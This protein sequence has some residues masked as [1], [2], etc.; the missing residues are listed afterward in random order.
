VIR[1]L[2]IMGRRRAA[3]YAG[4]GIALS[5]GAVAAATGIWLFRPSSGTAPGSGSFWRV[6]LADRATLGFLRLAVLMGA[7]YVVA[8]AAALIVGGR[9][10]R[11]IGSGGFEAD[12]RIADERM[13][14]LER[15]YEQVREDRDR[16]RRLLQEFEDG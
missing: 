11:S 5:V 2:F 12:A 4:A 13:A 16:A 6:L 7:L 10:I 8:S 1:K 14:A 15:R 9:W 3:E